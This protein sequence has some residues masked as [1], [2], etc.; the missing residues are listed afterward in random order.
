MFRSCNSHALWQEDGSNA[1][2][3]AAAQGATDMIMLMFKLH[4][5]KKDACLKSTNNHAM[6]SLHMAVL[7]DRDE[8]AQYLI[9]QVC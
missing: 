7:F 9:Q 2:H 4:P 5:E 8:T 3:L 6:T 1:V